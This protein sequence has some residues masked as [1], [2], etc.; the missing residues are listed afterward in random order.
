MKIKPY[1]KRSRVP[2]EKRLMHECRP[3][4]C[5]LLG[6]LLCFLLLTVPGGSYA[7]LEREQQGNITGGGAAEGFDYIPVSPQ[8]KTAEELYPYAPRNHIS[9]WQYALR[10][11]AAPFTVMF[12]YPRDEETDIYQTYLTQ[13]NKNTGR[14][15][16]KDDFGSVSKKRQKT[17][18][19]SEVKH[20]GSPAAT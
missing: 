13:V 14:T 1:R 15:W 20:S 11:L 6:C 9:V 2:R 3:V 7:S 17:E 8:E 16:K 4:R 5:F 10:I 18:A 12:T 19:L